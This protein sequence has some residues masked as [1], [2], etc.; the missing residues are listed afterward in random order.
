MKECDLVEIS[1][2]IL[3]IKNK[4]KEEIDKFYK[5]GINYLHIDVMDGKF[6]KNISLPYHEV[7]SI[8]TSDQKLDIHLMVSDVYKYVLDFIKLKPEY[9]TFHIEAVSNPLELINLIKKNNV[10]VGLAIKPSTN[11]EV[12][13]PYLDLIDLVLVMTVE[14]GMG[15]QELILDTISKIEDLSK[16]KDRH[17]KIEADGGIND[18][19]IHKLNK[20]DIAV[21]GSFLTNGDYKE[22]LKD[23]VK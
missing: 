3:G 22:R 4:T 6:V 14:P 5:S 20:L 7:E 12:I 10:K 2:S 15:G 21:V 9:I 18:K 1:G 17:F 16:I 19:T 8:V 11:I 23:V 13:K